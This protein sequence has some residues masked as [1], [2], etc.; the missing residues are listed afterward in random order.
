MLR[1]QDRIF[2]NLFGTQDWRLQGAR[3]R[4]LWDDTKGLLAR[5]RDAILDEIK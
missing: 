3:A 2:R 5:G 4:G 1:D